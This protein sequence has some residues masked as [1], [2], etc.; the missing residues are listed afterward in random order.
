MPRR[1][2]SP[3]RHSRNT[4]GGWLFYGISEASKEDA[5][6]GAFPG[7]ARRDVD[8]ALQRLRQAVA[9]L[10][11]PSPHYDP[12]VL[13]GPCESLGLSADCAIICV[14]IPWGPNA[15]YVHKS[16]QIYR[17]VADGSEPRPESDRFVLDQLWRR[18]EGLLK[19]YGAWIDRDPELSKTEAQNPYVRLLIVCDLWE[20]REAWLDADIAEVRGILGGEAG[21]VM[22]SLPFDTVYTSSQGF[23][24]RQLRNND[25][26]RLGL[27]WR[28]GRD[29]VSEVIIP[30]SYYDLNDPS[31]ASVHLEGFDGAERYAKM[32]HLAGYSQPKIVDLNL[33]Y[34]LLI[35]VA[36]TQSRLME[37][38]RWTHGFHIKAVLMNVWRTVPFLDLPMILDEFEKFGVPMILDE[39]VLAP[40]GRSPN[41]FGGIEPYLEI[42]NDAAR[43]LL[44]A[45]GMF[46]PIALAY[47]I[48]PWLEG[49][50]QDSSHFF[51]ELNE[52]GRRALAR[53]A[54]RNSD[55]EFR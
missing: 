18:S 26:Q 52:A 36:E 27:T 8:G 37:R 2:Q 40:A 25:P 33:L 35:G 21:I 1:W 54:H 14:Y 44:Q 50:G 45:I 6:A 12:R 55:R 29:L 49:G 28:L 30:L 17:R 31:A 24:G 42:E 43:P 5:V 11:N 38:A 20:E 3:L 41:S 23:I 13:W 22:T 7:I 34:N 9:G 16:G 51:T 10:I 4:H 39:S 48:P 46:A 47:G 15:P 32:L 53:Q 19:E